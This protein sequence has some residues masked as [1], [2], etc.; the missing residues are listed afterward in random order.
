MDW[1]LKKL[2]WRIH[3]PVEIRYVHRGEAWEK[4]VVR[5]GMDR[6]SRSQKSFTLSTS[7]T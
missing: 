2:L 6:Y 5:N 4:E 7:T 3:K 1:N